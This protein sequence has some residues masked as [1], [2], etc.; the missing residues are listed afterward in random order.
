MNATSRSRRPRVSV[1]RRAVVF[2][3]N[4]FTLFNLFC[5][6][7]AIVLAARQDFPTATLFVVIVGLL[8]ARKAE[9]T[10][11]GYFLAASEALVCRL[12]AGLVLHL[13]ALLVKV[14]ALYLNWL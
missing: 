3:P 7:Y 2:L 10:T 9:R 8:A 6:I 1:R 5:G 12:R 14:C 13:L 11:E 4:G